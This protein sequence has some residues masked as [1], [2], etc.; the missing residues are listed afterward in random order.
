MTEPALLAQVPKPEVR[1]VNALMPNRKA[2]HLTA[3]AKAWAEAERAEDQTGDFE[4]AAEA[5]AMPNNL[6]TPLRRGV[7]ILC[8]NKFMPRPRKCRRIC[9]R[10]QSY[11]FKPRGVPMRHL[12][13]VVLT[14]EEVEALRLKD[15][16]GLEQIEAARKMKTSQSTFQR[17]LT[18]G[19][20][21]VS[22]SIIH[23]KALKIEEK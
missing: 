3:G 10:G 22:S 12:E 19:R 21:K 15:F 20:R 7:S 2:D 13:E 1:W 18:S 17:I 16:L 6:E 23:G 11:Y 5:I 14:M 8:Y 9:W 4:A